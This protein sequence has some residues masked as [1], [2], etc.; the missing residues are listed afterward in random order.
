[1]A[2]TTDI[3]DSYRA[4]GR[5][6]RR[7][8]SR[9]ANEGRAL[10]LLMLGCAM[11]FVAQWPRLSREAALDPDVPREALFVAALNGWIFIMPILLYLLAPVPHLI[12]KGF[13]GK[14][15]WFDARMALFWA[16]VAAS[17]VWLF[18]GIVAGFLGAGLV[19]TVL[20]L[21]AIGAFFYIWVGGVREAEWPRNAAPG[22]NP[23]EP[24]Q[25]T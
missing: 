19:K 18:Q 17:P 14:G 9:G 24:R 25:S 16:I 1:M 6:L 10:M 2:I 12:A 23:E 13:G 4:P 3:V 22:P 20:A 21:V 7:Q 11:M 5:V 8:L 15:S